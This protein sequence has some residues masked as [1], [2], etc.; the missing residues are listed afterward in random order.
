MLQRQHTLAILTE[1]CAE[2]GDRQLYN[3]GGNNCAYELTLHQAK[4]GTIGPRHEL[5]H[6]KC[7]QLASAQQLLVG[8]QQFGIEEDLVGELSVGFT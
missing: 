8:R 6:H 5:I 2:E 1:I 7:L 3:M 4:L